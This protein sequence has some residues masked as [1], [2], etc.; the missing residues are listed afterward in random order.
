MHPR[1]NRLFRSLNF[2]FLRLSF[3]IMKRGFVV[4]WILGSSLY[5]KTQLLKHLRNGSFSFR[6][7]H[8]LNLVIQYCLVINILNRKTKK[9]L[10][11]EF[12]INH[13]LFLRIQDH[14]FSHNIYVR[15]IS[16]NKINNS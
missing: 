4:N 11:T 5:H 8:L 15:E 7:I 16:I 6:I 13:R 3:A 12:V 10:R 14:V 1:L 9:F 2:I